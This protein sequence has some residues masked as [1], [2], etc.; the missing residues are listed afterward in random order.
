[1]NPL[2]LVILLLAPL[3]AASNELDA[4]IVLYRHG[5]RTP[6]DPYPTDPY[7][8]TSYWPVG[9][10]Q[11]TNIG[12][13]QH[14]ELGKWLRNRYGD[15]LP[16][17]YSEEDI[18]VRSTDVDRT[19]MSAYSNLAGLYEP[20]G[21]QIWNANIDWQ[22]I[23][24]HT[25]PEKEDPVLAMKKHCPRY[26][27]LMSQLFLSK[28]FQNIANKY[29]EL[30]EYLTQMTGKT[31]NDIAQTEYIFNTL[32]IEELYNYT[33][34][35]WTNKVYPT[36]MQELAQ[37]SFAVP[38][39]TRELTRLNT[40]LLINEFIEHMHESISENADNEKK[41]KKVWMY[42]AH[43]TTVANVLSAL[44]LFE[45]HCP[46]YAS[47][48]ILEL[49]HNENGLRYVNVLYKNSTEARQMRLPE[50]DEN[51]PL[52]NFVAL[53]RDVTI[54]PDEWEEDCELDRIDPATMSMMKQMIVIGS[55]SIALL[56]TF[57]ILIYILCGTTKK[58]QQTYF[59]LPDS[60]I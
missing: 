14:F 2:H 16:D 17:K 11:L 54:T 60:E 32:F 13:Q 22:P 18:Y 52:N 57:C 48:V 39:Y 36:G 23:P 26:N 55:T 5:D 7:R 15:F 49:K 6:V 53:L 51:C 37:L 41:R 29:K 59:R 35:E 28:E 9:F 30:Y 4:V 21:G 27:Q 10:G 45:H 56:L 25:K 33:L 43:D 34:P 1:M 42:S 12:K 20:R 38:C 47:T 58:S 31:V 19:L 24:V 8:N 44:R 3:F 40:G 46:P 50:C